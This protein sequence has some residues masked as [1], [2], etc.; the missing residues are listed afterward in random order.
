MLERGV[1]KAEEVEG[2]GTLV[3]EDADV[4]T[5]EDMLEDDAE[6]EEYGAPTTLR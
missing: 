4:N 3:D 1:E 2:S 5:L 6:A